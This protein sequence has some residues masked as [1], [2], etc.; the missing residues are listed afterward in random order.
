VIWKITSFSLVV[1]VKLIYND[2]AYPLNSIKK[3]CINIF[4]TNN[5]YNLNGFCQK[6]YNLNGLKK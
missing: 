6:K 1:R 3:N 4:P 2:C 5:I